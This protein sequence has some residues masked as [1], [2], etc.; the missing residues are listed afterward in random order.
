MLSGVGNLT[1]K[2]EAKLSELIKKKILPWKKVI[3]IIM[4]HTDDEHGMSGLIYRLAKAGHRVIIIVTTRSDDDE[5]WAKRQAEMTRAGAILGIKA[6]DI[7]YLGEPHGK[8]EVTAT[9]QDEFSEFLN[10]LPMPDVVFCHSP[11]DIHPD[12]RATALLAMRK[13]FGP[14]VNVPFFLFALNSATWRHQNVMPQ[15]LGFYPTHYCTIPFKVVKIMR[16]ADA[17]HVSQNGTEVNSMFRGVELSLRSRGAEAGGKTY[18]EGFM[19]ITPY[20]APPYW[21]TERYLRPYK[22]SQRGVPFKARKPPTVP[23]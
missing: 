5:M 15:T 12:H 22:Q 19:Y 8:L 17:C 21:L 3:Y 4:S 23:D 14:G 2:M 18:A 11:I 10:Y 13:Y 20:G 7:H 16:Q 9:V 6:D 1:S